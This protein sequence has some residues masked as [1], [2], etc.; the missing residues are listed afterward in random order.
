[1]TMLLNIW[2]QIPRNWMQGKKH[3]QE[4]ETENACQGKLLCPL[5]ISFPDDL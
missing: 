5:S 3:Y 1:M 2:K 4:P